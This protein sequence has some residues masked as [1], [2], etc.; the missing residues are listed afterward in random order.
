MELYRGH[1]KTKCAS[2]SIRAKVAW[3]NIFR[4]RDSRPSSNFNGKSMVRGVIGS[5]DLAMWWVSMVVSSTIHIHIQ[6]IL[7]VE[8]I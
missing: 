1:S 6:K 8:V 3:S 5:T 4:D 7:G 2:I